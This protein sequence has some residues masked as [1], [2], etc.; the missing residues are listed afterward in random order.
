MMYLTY[1]SNVIEVMK[2]NSEAAKD[3]NGLLNG[4]ESE[5]PA[6][7]QFV[8]IKI[9]IIFNDKFFTILDH[10]NFNFNEFYEDFIMNLNMILIIKIK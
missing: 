7:L 8:F 2:S 4:D 9:A 3:E 5:F 10:F 1:S 6:S